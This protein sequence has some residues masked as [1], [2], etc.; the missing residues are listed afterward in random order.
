MGFDGR[1]LD[2]LDGKGVLARGTEVL[3]IG[4]QNLFFAEPAAL[5]RFFDRHHASVS[6]EDCR[7]LAEGG[8]RGPKGVRQDSWLGEVLV[9]A[10]LSYRAFDVLDLPRT[11]IFDLNFDA[12][13][14]K[15]VGRFDLVLNFGTTE[16]VFNQYNAFK[17]IHDACRAGGW[18][19]SG[20]GGTAGGTRRRNSRPKRPDF[21]DYRGRKKLCDSGSIG[22]N[23]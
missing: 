15:D 7:R 12:L 3:D 18:I 13:A 10:G 21:W 22:I 4:T 8:A 17:I 6:D 19:R 9:R 11:E 23:I 16:H 2:Y 5:K 1:Y 14:P 20:R